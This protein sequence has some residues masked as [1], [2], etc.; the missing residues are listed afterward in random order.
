MLMQTNSYFV[1]AE[2][3]TEHERIM[4]RFREILRR[5]GC[6]NFEVYELNGSSFSASD[7][8][9]RFLQVMKFRDRHHHHTVRDAER[10]DQQAQDLIREFCD[11]VDYSYQHDQ[12][13]ATIHYYTPMSGSEGDPTNIP[14][15]PSKPPAKP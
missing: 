11:L 7:G 12:G 3:R 5:L 2:K 10:H 9:G 15:G 6:D 13:L 8:A 14:P 4:R 1:P